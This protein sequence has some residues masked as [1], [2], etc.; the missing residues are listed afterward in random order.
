MIVFIA[1]PAVSGAS[2]VVSIIC[3]SSAAV[4]SNYMFALAAIEAVFSIAVEIYAVSAA[5]TAANWE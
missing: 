5:V 2:W 4:V 3:A 1:V